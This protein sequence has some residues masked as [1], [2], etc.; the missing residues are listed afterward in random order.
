[1]FVGKNIRFYLLY[2]EYFVNLQQVAANF[3]TCPQ[4]MKK[5]LEELFSI[6]W[7]HHMLLI[8][9]CKGNP[10]KFLVELGTG[11]AYMGREYRLQIGELPPPSSPLYLVRGTPFRCER[12]MQTKSRAQF[13]NW[14]ISTLSH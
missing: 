8:D 9:K 12:S 3:D 2:N 7:G 11:F 5:Y 13:I 10:K 6:P 14:H 1:M 4:F